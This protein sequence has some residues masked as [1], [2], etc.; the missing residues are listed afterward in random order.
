MQVQDRTDIGVRVYGLA[1]AGAQLMAWILMICAMWRFIVGDF[2]HPI[3]LLGLLVDH[4]GIERT[5]LYWMDK[6]PMWSD[7][8]IV[9]F[10]WPMYYVTGLALYVVAF[11]I[12]IGVFMNVNWLMTRSRK[13]S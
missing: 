13:T 11:L 3:S 7:G 6:P 10:Q 5:A 4:L 8:A 9:L 2:R 1:Y 12:I